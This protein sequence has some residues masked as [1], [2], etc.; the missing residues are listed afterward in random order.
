MCGI[1]LAKLQC[2]GIS[3]FQIS[4][5]LHCAVLTYSLW[6]FISLQTAVRH[7]V[8][9]HHRSPT[10]NMSSRRQAE[11]SGGM[12]AIF[13]APEMHGMRSQQLATFGKKLVH[14]LSVRAAPLPPETQPNS[15]ILSKRPHFVWWSCCELGG[16]SY[17]AG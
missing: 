8:H 16:D 14:T 5:S 4:M 11:R 1:P 12:D 2:V 13:T 3:E 9:I 17:L 10:L 7:S 15:A 6:S